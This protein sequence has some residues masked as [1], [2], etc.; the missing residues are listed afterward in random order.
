MYNN[1]GSNYPFKGV[2]KKLA[3]YF[4]CSTNF[5]FS[6]CNLNLA[7]SVC[8]ARINT[9]GGC[10]LEYATESTA[11]CFKSNDSHIRLVGNICENCWI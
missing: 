4:A 10:H 7:K 8:L 9:I 5:C 11:T 3:N 2:C 6:K 1:S